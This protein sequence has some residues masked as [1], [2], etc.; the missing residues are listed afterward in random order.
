MNNEQLVFFFM[1]IALSSALYLVNEE[2]KSNGLVSPKKLTI[3]ISLFIISFGVS[4]IIHL[5]NK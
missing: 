4:V 1:I 2:I 3:S 5:L